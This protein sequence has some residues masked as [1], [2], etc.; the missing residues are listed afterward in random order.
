LNASPSRDIWW[1]A[2]AAESVLTPRSAPPGCIVD[3]LR[4]TL[5]IGGNTRSPSRLLGEG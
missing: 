2:A 1:A 3:G 4:A 5:D